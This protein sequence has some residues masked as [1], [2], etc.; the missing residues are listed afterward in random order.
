MLLKIDDVLGINNTDTVSARLFPVLLGVFVGLG[1]ADVL[2][3]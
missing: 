1:I 2:L 3:K